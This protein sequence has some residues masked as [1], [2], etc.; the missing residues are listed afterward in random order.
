MSATVVLRSKVGVFS[1]HATLPN[2]KLFDF[3]FKE[4]VKGD[5]QFVA[6]VPTVVTYVDDFNKTQPYHSNYAEFL[7][8]NYPDILEVLEIKEEPT[9]KDVPEKSAKRGP[10]RPR[11]VDVE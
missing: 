4:K 9:I 11:K 5:G 8:H 2:G 1:T 3:H 7:L 10:G 6:E